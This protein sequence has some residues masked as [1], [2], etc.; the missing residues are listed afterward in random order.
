M[1]STH[2]SRPGVAIERVD[3][4]R[5]PP[6]VLRTDVATFVGTAQRGPIDTPVPVESMRQFVTHFGAFLGTSYLAYA[7][8]GFFENGGRRC[9]VVR[10][11]HREFTGGELPA[12][13]ACPARLSI[14][15]EAGA[16]ALRIVAS[17][18]GTW[19]NEL[20]LEWQVSGAAVTVSVP[21]QSTPQYSVVTST[22]GF[23]QNELVR[24]EQ[25]AIVHYR[26]IACVD[27]I[28]RQ[29]YWVHPDPQSVRDTDLALDGFDPSRPLRIL[30]TAY[31]LA[32][33]EAGVV[34]AS[35]PDLHL[36][37]RHP[38]YVC[39]VLRAPSY[40]SAALG[41]TVL[42]TSSAADAS[43]RDANAIPPLP[44]PPGPIVISAADSGTVPRLTPLPLAVPF[45]G[46]MSLAAGTDGLAQLSVADFLGEP[47]DSRDSDFTRARKSRGL[48]ALALIDEISLVAMPDLLIQPQHDPDYAPVPQP[49]RNPCVWCPPA[50]GPRRFHQPH[51]ADELPPIFSH[52]AIA[53]AQSALLDSCEAL[54]RFAVLSLP[55]D[56]ATAPERSRADMVAWR[57]QF[58]ARCGALYAPWI[59]VSE[60]RNTAP[61]RLVPPC[62]HVIG[63]IARNDV[64]FGVQ[65]AP[66]NIELRGVIAVAKAMDDALHGFLND[67]GLDV[68]RVE[69]GRSPMIG[70]A[71]TLGFDAEWRYVNVV[72]L[73]QTIQKAADLAL[74]FVVFEPNDA[75]LRATVR[76][77]LLAVMQLFFVRGAFAG[78]TEAE[79]FFVRCDEALNPPEARDAG[80]LLALVGFA[81]ATPAEFIVLRV[82]RQL[83]APAVSLFSATEL[84]Q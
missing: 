33:R 75:V 35:Y 76:A 47:W 68:L 54:G 67:S 28:K 49:P 83:N 3:A 57:M 40:W 66:G 30:R 5:I 71:R 19:G 82:G 62:G 38:R 8:R 9:W 79:S 22:A 27:A 21:A 10:V 80:Q 16:P 41:Q 72:R 55:F 36:V 63:A 18:A 26:V 56:I 59:A 73:M 7:V 43:S 13:G 52:E 20:S 24:I 1:T 65:Q 14:T 23:A 84:V 29:I 42:D 37:P 34:V 78:A 46:S 45:D 74:R 58:D 77:T 32:V 17:S 6:I 64:D 25:G 39:A 61:T 2:D 70:G 81:P 69:Y 60:P 31:S 50:C 12:A 44:R 15:D 4:S 53:R 48:Q 11:A 51:G